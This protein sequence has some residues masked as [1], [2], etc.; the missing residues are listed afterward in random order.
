[1]ERKLLAEIHLVSRL[2]LGFIFIYHGLVPKIIWLHPV[3]IQLTTAHGLDA[4]FISPVAGVLEVVLG[5]S[6]LLMRKSLLPVYI[7]IASL[8]MLLLDVMLIM[9]S[10]L[11]AA[12]NP[13]TTNLVAIAM[14]Y[15]VVVTRKAYL[16]VDD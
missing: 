15:I 6:L 4:A 5:L 11:T 8:V 10:L 7:A 12:F 14:A 2:V 3:E 16:K 13:V 9:P 1:M